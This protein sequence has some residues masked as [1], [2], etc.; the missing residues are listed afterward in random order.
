MSH[1]APKV[2]EVA[3]KLGKLPTGSRVIIDDHV[4]IR[5]QSRVSDDKFWKMHQVPR[6]MTLPVFVSNDYLA[7]VAATSGYDY[8]VE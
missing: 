8:E 5:V 2:R 4:F 1:S 3:K 7:E 6:K